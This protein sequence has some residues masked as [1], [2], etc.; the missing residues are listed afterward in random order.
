MV[1]RSGVDSFSG[2]CL[3][4]L[5]VVQ[6]H[7][8]LLNRLLEI[9]AEDGVIA[10]C[11][12]HWQVLRP[13]SKV[14][15]SALAETLRSVN[16]EAAVEVDMVERIGRELALALQGQ[17]DPLQLLFPGG[18]LEEM[19]KLY[20]DAPFTRSFN[21]L[22]GE[23]AR[24]LVNHWQA[25][26]PLRILEIGAGTGGTTSHVLAQ[27]SKVQ[28]E[29]T[30]TDVSPLFLKR[31]QQKLSAYD[32][33][34]YRTL[35]IEKDPV[36]QGFT[37]HSYDLVL[38]T[39][40]LHATSNLHDTLHRV[41][42][43]IAPGGFLI[44]VE[45][46]RKQRFADLIVGL[47]PGWWAF[48]DKDLRS[49]YALASQPE[50]LKLLGAGGFAVSEGVTGQAALSNQSLL[51]AQAEQSR[52][53]IEAGT[54]L[55][56]SESN[57]LSGQLAEKLQRQGQSTCFVKA[58]KTFTQHENVYQV[59]AACADDF[60]QLIQ[61]NHQLNG[62][63]YLWALDH[64]SDVVGGQS[65]LCGGLLYLVQALIAREITCPIWVVTRGAQSAMGRASFPQP[66]TLWG[67]CKVINQE[68]PEISCH[69]IDL[70]A[71]W[72]ASD[73]EN[74]DNLW[75]EISAADSEDQVAYRDN[76]RLVPRL[77]H[78]RGGD[79]EPVSKEPVRLAVSDRGVLDHLA[80]QKL[81]RKSPGPGEVEIQVIATGI[82][83][84]DV[85][86]TLGMYPGG[87]E[88]GSECAG[89]VTAVGPGVENVQ[90]GDSVIAFAL[91]SFGSY[92]VTPARHLVPKPVQLTFA[93]A[94]TIPSAF[95]TSQ[96][97]LHHLAKIK[98]GDR[99]LI[100]AAAGGVGLAAIQ[101]A[102]RSEAEIFATAGSPAKRKLLTSLGVQYV[103]DS[104]SF[105]FADEI[106]KLTDGQGVDIVLNSLADEFIPR[107]VSVLAEDGRFIEIGKRGIWS[108]A[109]FTQL[110]PGAEYKTVDLLTESKQDEKLIPSLFQ[111][112]MPLFKDGTLE[113]LP[114]QVYP[115]SEVVE[116]FRY[117]A[118]GRHIGKLVVL[119]E[120]PQFAI[121]E[122]ATYM[123]TGG[124]GGLGL[125]VAT[126]LVDLGAKHLVL[127]G[128]SSP[129]AQA[130]AAVQKMMQAGVAV[131]VL[132]ADVSK[133][134]EMTH[135]FSQMTTSMPALRGVF[136]AAGVLDDGVL[137]QQ[138]WERFA[139]V[140]APKVQGAWNLHELTKG[141]SL[142][143]FVL[144]SS[145]VSL[146]GSA[147]QA[148]HVA[149]ST[150]LDMLAHY[151]QAQGLPALS[152]DWGPWTQI[153]AAAEREVSERLLNRGVESISPAEG[154]EALSSIMDAPRFTQ[155]AIV[156]VKWT[157]FTSQNSSP[158][159]AQLKELEQAK[160]SA[161]KTSPRLLKQE[162]NLW[163]RLENAPESKRKN[164]LMAHVRTQALKVL[165]LPMDFALE[166]RQPL[167]ELGL[168]SLMAVELRNLLGKGLPLSRALP[169]TLVFDYPT[170]EA[171]S[172][173][174]MDDLFVKSP[175]SPPSAQNEKSVK[176]DTEAGLSD[177]EA[178]ALLL[179]ELNELK[180]RKFEK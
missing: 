62:I 77:I 5:S 154:I 160:T 95:L 59:D 146:L 46:T 90:P 122:D 132:Q 100:H 145:A 57:D 121:H 102:Q 7:R 126:W 58:G 94:A 107:S 50:W 148:N 140:F 35:D 10:P 120:T 92:V 86:N 163:Q 64:A 142:D 141:L 47:T 37:A 43:L 97:A 159:F 76:E 151:R 54:W 127:V 138:T 30:F 98:V 156:P 45:G 25:E 106:M 103:M 178:E 55:L 134:A 143:F 21:Q 124:L 41:R 89:I 39:N 24:Q 96:Y 170:P 87:G 99:I 61:A 52:P 40:V 68:H 27:L 136:H 109:Q 91:G 56:F 173:Y 13:L 129:R 23:A 49:S 176:N 118:Q 69:S 125:A 139:A 33:V 11:D 167:Q 149:A 174:L 71:G 161:S 147:G 114:L 164:L 83:F 67:L 6:Q 84:R 169:A 155:V 166:Q 105:D 20:R 73:K 171:L 12:E 177:E 111:E 144:F 42:H 51:V 72:L 17:R 60:H 19:E 162:E 26:R 133:W 116:A 101:L 15:A 48:S 44:A 165:N 36:T 137:S 9:L 85:L 79:D 157:Q 88:L 18:S 74:L 172:R 53:T 130:Q 3:T 93:Q 117:M 153:G 108:H 81:S 38:A 80:Y 34:Q 28:A 180:N 123:I 14:N 66:A 2:G 168:D 150:F 8:R 1:V 152:I 175:V 29:Y 16:P 113:P 22:A 119:Q 135:I 115:A 128:R 65:V 112:I 179:A 78:A 104:R 70:D 75:Q 82:G 158:F 32:F 31:A 131:K 63:V 4:K 110:R